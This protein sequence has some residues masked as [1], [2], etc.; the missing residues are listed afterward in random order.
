MRVLICCD[1]IYERNT[2]RLRKQ[3]IRKRN[4]EE[5]KCALDNRFEANGE[6]NQIL[7]LAQTDHIYADSF[8]VCFYVKQNKLEKIM[9]FRYLFS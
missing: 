5:K 4:K 7:N 9:Y 6:L 8:L 2:R 3:S 1:D